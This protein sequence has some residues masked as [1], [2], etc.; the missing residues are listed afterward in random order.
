[1]TVR[2]AF[3]AE[4]DHEMAMTRRVLERVPDEQFA[5]KPHDKSFSMG[6][7]ATHLSQLPHWGRQILSQESYDLASA[8]TKAAER[9]TR[10]EVLDNFD[11]HVRD[12]RTALVG[13]SDAE[14]Q[15]IWTLKRGG[16]TVLSMPRLQALNSFLIHH[17]IHH[18]GQL[19]VYLRLQ[20]VPL[21][22]IYGPTADER[23]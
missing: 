7:L 8:S 18:R 16:H 6:G 10:A 23:M 13:S 15:A 20:G 1:M 21:P 19:T 22:P 9:Q 2:D 5:W 12:V 11:H 4:F 14:L 3:V 17:V